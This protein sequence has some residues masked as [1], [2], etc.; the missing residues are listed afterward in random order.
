VNPGRLSILMALAESEAETQGSLGFTDLRRRTRLSDG[1]L[2]CHAQRL[3]TGGL[4]GIA[5]QFR[6]GKP[7]TTYLLTPTGRRALEAHV[8]RLLSVVAPN[9][10]STLHLAKAAAHS[11]PV[12]A[13]YHQSEDDWVD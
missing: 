2:S 7:S 11:E 10:T 1:N 6:D 13:Q 8:H 12:G 9:S 4:I 5:K 3:A